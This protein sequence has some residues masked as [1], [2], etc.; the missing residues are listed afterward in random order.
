MI[1][2]RALKIIFTTSIKLG[3][4]SFCIFLILM[5]EDID[6]DNLIVLI[7]LGSIICSII[8][9]TASILLF[10]PLTYYSE[11]TGDTQSALDM[12]QQLLPPLVLLFSPL[13]I[14]PFLSSDDFDYAQFS[15]CYSTFFSAIIGWLIYTK[16]YCKEANNKFK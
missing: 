15:F 9:F 3:P 16:D 10:L 1:N 7:I 4:I 8:A 13:T 5:N 14:I 11:K 2:G 6:V 12:F